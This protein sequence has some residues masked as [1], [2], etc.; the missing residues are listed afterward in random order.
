MGPSLFPARY[1]C[2]FF[3]GI[4]QCAKRLK[5]PWFG[6]HFRIESPENLSFF[7]VL[8]NKIQWLSK[9]KLELNFLRKARHNPSNCIYFL[10]IYSIDYGGRIMYKWLK[11]IVGWKWIVTTFNF[12]HNRE[13][14]GWNFSKMMYII[15]PEFQPPSPSRLNL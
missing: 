9:A 10:P 15:L 13:L 5:R 1:C 8:C 6:A 2:P 3:E 4:M 12:W 11:W 14:G 7:I